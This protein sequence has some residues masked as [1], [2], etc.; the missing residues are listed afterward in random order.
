MALRRVN[1]ELLRLAAVTLET[2]RLGV[3][4]AAAN[5][6][7]AELFP[8]GVPP[9]EPFTRLAGD[10]H[11]F[12]FS[13]GSFVEWI[14]S[15]ERLP[16]ANDKGEFDSMEVKIGESVKTLARLAATLNARFVS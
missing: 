16:K 12:N 3:L 6:K 7:L 10:P 1:I 4:H 14:D 15:I 2:G 8:D 13:D 11:E 5:R 9:I